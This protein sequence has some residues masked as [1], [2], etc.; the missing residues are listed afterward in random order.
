[1]KMMRQGKVVERG[2][3]LTIYNMYLYTVALQSRGWAGLFKMLESQG[4][5]MVDSV[6]AKTIEFSKTMFTMSKIIPYKSND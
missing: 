2:T 5:F 3:E 6:R 1:M 4:L